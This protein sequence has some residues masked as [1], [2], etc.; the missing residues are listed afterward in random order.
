MP[1]VLSRRK[2]DE[3]AAKQRRGGSAVAQP[4]HRLLSALYGMHGMLRRMQRVH[5]IIE[6]YY[7]VYLGQGRDTIVLYFNMY[8]CGSS[9]ST[10]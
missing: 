1:Q 8:E 3:V 6:Y 5:I 7:I 10:R 9:T 2:N 4:L